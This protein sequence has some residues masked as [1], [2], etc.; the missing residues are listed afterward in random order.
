MAMS[1]TRGKT[2]ISF[3]GCGET[4]G[5]DLTYGLPCIYFKSWLYCLLN[6]KGATRKSQTKNPGICLF[7]FFSKPNLGESN[8]IVY[9][10]NIFEVKKSKEQNILWHCK[11]HQ[12]EL[13][14]RYNTLHMNS[15]WTSIIVW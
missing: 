11:H 3:Q 13:T 2:K 6:S 12:S 8:L 15:I 7:S 10:Q 5:H 1:V 9:V 14:R 4:L